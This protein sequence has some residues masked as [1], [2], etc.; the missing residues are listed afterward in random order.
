MIVVSNTEVENRQ[1]YWNS[2][3]QALS[4]WINPYL[5][6]NRK[7]W[8]QIALVELFDGNK[9]SKLYFDSEIRLEIEFNQEIL[10]NAT[11]G[12]K[13]QPNLTDIKDITWVN[14]DLDWNSA[15]ILIFKYDQDN[16]ILDFDFRYNQSDAKKSIDR[17]SE[18]LQ[19]SRIICWAKEY[20]PNVLIYLIWST[21]ELIIDTKLALHA[22]KPENNRSH[23]QKK[24][25]LILLEWFFSSEFS[26]L[27]L[28]ISS[29]KNSARYWE[30]NFN[31]THNLEWFFSQI[32]IL[33][34]E[35]NNTKK[36]M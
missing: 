27:F 25:K 29:I 6:E 9:W 7:A 31:E 11:I 8:F 5:Q 19:S 22:Q 15:K 21:A 33:Q 12:S 16:W 23:I 36:I 35:L 34:E 17:A 32:E 18:F 14:D 4:L 30:K 24:N 3:Q 28:E 26:N 20:N 2:I 13:Y 1:N 10:T